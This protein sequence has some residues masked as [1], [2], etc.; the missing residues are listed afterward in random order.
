M[1]A[2]S[3][4][5]LW[6]LIRED[7][8]HEL[9]NLEPWINGSSL[10]RYWNQLVDIEELSHFQTLVLQEGDEQVLAHAQ[11]IPFYWPE[12]PNCEICLLDSLEW[13][14]SLPDGGWETILARGIRQAR[15][16]R[17]ESP[18]TET[19]PLT[20]GQIQDEAVAWSKNNPNALSGLAVIVANK[21]R[22]AGIADALLI[23]FKT[24]AKKHNLKAVV[25]PL[26]PTLKYKYPHVS[27]SDYYKWTQGKSHQSGFVWGGE[28]DMRNEKPLPF[29][30]WLRKHIRMGARAIKLA[31]TSFSVEGT[32]DK[33]QDWL[34]DKIAL[35]K[36]IG[37]NGEAH[38]IGEKLD[39]FLWEDEFSTPLRW[40]PL[41]NVCRYVE[42]DMWVMHPLLNIKSTS[43][44]KYLV[45]T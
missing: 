10:P 6:K 19:S 17:G 20:D 42:I 32:A 9:W 39:G 18:T 24:L 36:V 28:K 22:D 8:T 26:R 29:D 12:L 1:S 2:A 25:V 41:A 45:L 43:F 14:L 5:D 44:Q 27:F 35:D 38:L 40:D 3:R 37:E 7:S 23:Y 11:C 30:P 16:R 15:A 33:W 21:Y 31:P 34:G 4:P 13:A